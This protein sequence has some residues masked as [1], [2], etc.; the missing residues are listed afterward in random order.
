MLAALQQL[1]EGVRALPPAAA[2]LASPERAGA[3]PGCGGI[4]RETQHAGLPRCDIC[5]S[6]EETNENLLLQ[7]DCCHVY[8]RSP[9]PSCWQ[10]LLVHDLVPCRV[11]ERVLNTC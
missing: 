1:P 8:V 11:L 7:C 5:S 3:R 2:Q 6:E 10:T 4:V 9:R